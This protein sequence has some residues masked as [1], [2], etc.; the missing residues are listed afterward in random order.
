MPTSI[1]ADTN[2]IKDDANCLMVLELQRQLRLSLDV[3]SNV[4]YR[5]LPSGAQCDAQLARDAMSGLINIRVEDF[6]KH[7]EFLEAH[8]LPVLRYRVENVAMVEV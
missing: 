3:V 1:A 2:E 6:R 8:G 4:C 5:Q 7:N